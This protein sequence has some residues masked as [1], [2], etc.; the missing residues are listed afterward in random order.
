LTR[1]A[2]VTSGATAMIADVPKKAAAAAAPVSIDIMQMTR[3]A[4]NLPIDQFDAF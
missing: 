4:K 3:D 2:T 1:V